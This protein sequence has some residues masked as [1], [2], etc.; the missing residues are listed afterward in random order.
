[1]TLSLN[2]RQMAK[3]IIFSIHPFE[4]EGSQAFLRAARTGNHTKLQELLKRN[5][6]LLF[7]FNNVTL[8]KF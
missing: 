5:R 7:D 3:N 2:N 4:K 8:E 6:Y 1:M